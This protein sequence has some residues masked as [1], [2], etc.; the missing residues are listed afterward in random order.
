MVICSAETLTYSLVSAK[1]GVLD[2]KPA[3]V[4]HVAWNNRVVSCNQ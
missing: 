3:M 2:G 4:L 1:T